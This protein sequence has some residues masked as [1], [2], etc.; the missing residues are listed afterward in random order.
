VELSES[1]RHQRFQYGGVV[2]IS[3]RTFDGQRN[4]ALGRCLDVSEQGLGLELSARIPVGSFVKLRAYKL[5]LDGSATVRHIARLPVG[6][7]LGLE[8]SQPLDPDV[9]AELGESQTD[10]AGA[11]PTPA[12]VLLER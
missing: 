6:Y 5:N 4:Y 3:W 2:F 10:A 7:G 9:L 11:A 1:R 8:L 12:P